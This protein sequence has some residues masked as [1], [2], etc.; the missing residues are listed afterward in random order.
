[1]WDVRM[2]RSAALDERGFLFLHMRSAIRSP[3]FEIAL[4]F[5][6]LDHVAVLIVNPK[7]PSA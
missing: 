1:M 2:A 3:L 6:R 4:V 7:L 5:V